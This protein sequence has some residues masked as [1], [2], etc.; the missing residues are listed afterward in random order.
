MMQ[1]FDS[2]SSSSSYLQSGQTSESSE[3]MLEGAALNLS[4]LNSQQ[5]GM[6]SVSQNSPRSEENTQEEK[7]GEK[8]ELDSMPTSPEDRFNQNQ[9]LILANEQFIGQE[10]AGEVVLQILSPIEGSFDTSK[11]ELVETIAFLNSDNQVRKVTELFRKLRREV[12]GTHADYKMMSNCYET[13]HFELECIYQKLLGDKYKKFARARITFK[14]CLK[15]IDF[16]RL[17]GS[18]GLDVPAWL[19]QDWADAISKQM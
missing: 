12:F 4:D 17:D 1:S 10:E 2:S 5:S 14:E 9:P 13:F 8:S 7:K 6:S 18:Y 3:M 16:E 11:K 19:S 15:S